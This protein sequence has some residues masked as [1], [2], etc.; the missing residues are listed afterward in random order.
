MAKKKKKT[1]IFTSIAKAF[2][3]L[4][5][6]SKKTKKNKST[7]ASKKGSNSRASLKKTTS[8]RPPTGK[9]YTGKTY[10]SKK[11]GNKKQN[12]SF[13]SLWESLYHNNVVNVQNKNKKATTQTP[14][15]QAYKKGRKTNWGIAKNNSAND[16]KGDTQSKK[17]EK[18]KKDGKG[19]NNSKFKTSGEQI[20]GSG[21]KVKTHKKYYTTKDGK[22]IPY[23]FTDLSRGEYNLLSTWAQQ[24]RL[25]EYLASNKK[26]AEKVLAK[27]VDDYARNGVS[28]GS[29]GALS[30]TTFGNDVSQNYRK[31]TVKGKDGKSKTITKSNYDDNQKAII[32]DVKSSTAYKVGEAVGEVFNFGVGGTSGL[33]KSIASSLLKKG[34]KSGVKAG[35][36]ATAKAE[37]KNLAGNIIKAGG[38]KAVTKGGKSV[39]KK[40]GKQFAKDAAAETL[41]DVIASVPLN[42]SS[43]VKDARDM[44]GNFDKKTFA[45]SLGLNTA[46]DAVLGG[47]VSGITKAVT[48]KQAKN[49]LN[50]QSKLDAGEALSKTEEESY[51]KLLDK[52]SSKQD[53]GATET[54]SK[55]AK[56]QK[57]MYK[58]IADKRMGKTLSSEDQKFYND[59]VSVARKQRIEALTQ[60]K[61]NEADVNND[62]GVTL[63]TPSVKSSADETGVKSTQTI[64]AHTMSDNAGDFIRTDG[65]IRTGNS[66]ARAITRE[67]LGSNVAKKSVNSKVQTAQRDLVSALKRGENISAKARVYA[68]NIIRNTDNAKLDVDSLASKL[69]DSANADIRRGNGK[70]FNNASN[71]SVKK[72]ISELKEE[73]PDISAKDLQA[74][75]D[76]QF[77]YKERSIDD[78][79]ESTSE[80]ITATKPGGKMKLT[81]QIRELWKTG[82]RRFVDEFAD[83][84][85]LAKK[86]IKQ[87]DK[88]GDELLNQ[89]NAD[90]NAA[91]RGKAWIEI[92][93]RNSKGEVTGESL[94]D[95][96][97]PYLKEGQEAE[98]DALQNYMFHK[99]NIDRAAQ[100][101]PVFSGVTAEESRK[102]VEAL[103]K[104]YPNL[105]KDADKI[106][107]YLKDLQKERIDAGLMSQERAD[108]LDELYGSYVPTYRVK[109]SSRLGGN[110]YNLVIGSR[111]GAVGGD[112]DLMPLHEQLTRLTIRTMQDAEMNRTMNIVADIV[113]FERKDLPAEI[114][115]EDALESSVILGNDGKTVTFWRDGEKVEMKVDSGIY[116]GLKSW[117]SADKTANII[118]RTGAGATS[119][120]KK[121]I[122]DWN[123]IFTV[124]NGFRDS[125]EGTMYSKASPAK[126]I[127]N[128]GKAMRAIT[129]RNEDE[130]YK[131]L[132][133][134]YQEN[135]GKFSNLIDLKTS[136]ERKL[137]GLHPLQRLEEINN[138]I[139]SLP[140]VAEFMSTLERLGIDINNYHG[141]AIDKKILNEAMRDANDV[142]LNFSRTGDITR[143]L[144]RTFV[145]FLTPSIQGFDKLVRTL[146]GQRGMAAAMTTYLKLGS[147]G[148]APAVFNEVVLKG[149]EGYENLNDRDKDSNYI[150][151][152]GDGKFIKLPKSRAAAAIST[153]FTEAYRTWKYGDSYD[154]KYVFDQS[155]QQSGVVNPV[156]N[157]IIMPIIRIAQNKTWY[158]GDIE[159]S[160]DQDFRKAGK[161]DKIFDENTSLLSKA[162]GG[163]AVAKKLGISP[164]QMD[165]LADSYLGIIGD[166]IIPAT[167]QKNTT[168][169]GRAI[170]IPAAIMK[171]VVMGNFT[172]DSVF[173]NKLAVDFYDKMDILDA[174]ASVGKKGSKAES[175]H[176][177]F[178]TN[179]GYAAFDYT[180]AISDLENNTKLSGKVKSKRLRELRAAYNDLLEAGIEGREPKENHVETIGRITGNY[181]KAIKEYAGEGH[182]KA[183]ENYEKLNGYKNLS[184]SEKRKRSKQF[185]NVYSEADSIR[186]RT[187]GNFN[188]PDYTAVALA[189]DGKKNGK[190]IAKAYDVHDDKLQAASFYHKAGKTNDDYVTAKNSLQKTKKKNDITS[191]SGALIS[192][193]LATSNVK[194]KKMTDADYV[195]FEGEKRMNPARGLATYDWTAKD[196]KNVIDLKNTIGDK[197]GYFNYNEAVQAV[198]SSGAKDDQEKACLFAMI[199][200]GKRN[201]YGTVNDYSIKG[202]Y[203]YK[204]E[205]TSSGGY[206]GRS[207]GGYR[208]SGGRRGGSGGGGTTQTWESFLAELGFDV[209]TSTTVKS[210]ASKRTYSKSALDEAYRKRIRLIQE[211]AARYKQKS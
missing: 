121:L 97:T 74:K 100:G 85:D 56:D 150:I 200:D 155:W 1:N 209:D 106:Y 179:Y 23:T 119:L 203:G 15:Y 29:Q 68:D 99:H 137:G 82:K 28:A 16:K 35:A 167:A 86:T 118:V 98:Y 33:G 149:A 185:M 143:T 70:A 192:M 38:K 102:V 5:G 124:K 161:T 152:M 96:F 4:T 202:D 112:D 26:L 153:P 173:T 201:P 109:E 113:G 174:E 191:S 95:I 101:K 117:S 8:W 37:T 207:Y 44:E 78:I 94:K 92:K 40:N 80:K 67:L 87:G 108:F 47:A 61:L 170:D 172:L 54:I 142:T 210:S 110:D 22:K 184:Y 57:R 154:W 146:A 168:S 171:K 166:L 135:G 122:I 183:F 58:I 66:D 65:T 42:V 188:Y 196:V 131:Q 14:L 11:G 72:Y 43:A 60:K 147:I 48:A 208:R 12:T 19:N 55:N 30:R 91:G 165:N 194:G 73:N 186:K 145:P 49:F 148:I 182:A 125:V 144:N 164:K 160:A 134:L 204:E 140:R 88:R 20:S 139:E 163:T 17:D 45:A 178:M 6:G 81:E 51:T 129:G 59:N 157:M 62:G 93:R 162:L 136:I 199:Y 89:V 76:E 127:Q 159:N 7:S 120:F 151:P 3:K 9:T 84:E 103:G 41:G 132:L 75:V 50:L 126:F 36:K 25:N 64:S 69:V 53:G 130:S 187:N 197:N 190:K 211:N 10:S 77:G 175:E 107:G 32:E 71:A 176:E 138:A 46:G 63:E 169:S 24:G 193:S 105:N 198:E 195:I 116:D 18:N 158:G 83:L 2:K 39:V 128:Y 180:N 123:P 104:K 27:N 13:S 90:R 133:R 141:E 21:T 156:D 205:T 111:K 189:V 177:K 34:I 115:A 206:S 31:Q 114:S 52:L 181:G 79:L